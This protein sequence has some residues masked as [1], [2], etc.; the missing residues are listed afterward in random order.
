MGEI[1]KPV[2]HIGYPKTATSWLQR[3]F[4]PKVK[5][6]SII[7]KNEIFN[8][9]IDIQDYTPDVNLVRKHFNSYSGKVIISDHGF[10]GTN[11]NFGV[12]NYLTRENGIRLKN[13]FPESKIIIFIRNQPDIIASTYIQY[14]KAG[15]TYS[16]AKYLKTKRFLKLNDITFFSF[17]YFEYHRI[18]DFYI[19]LFGRQNV[20]VYIFE[21][22]VANPRNF[23]E[24]FAQ[25][26]GFVY[27]EKEIDYS[28]RNKRLRKLLIKL[29]RVR[30][31]F[32][33]KNVINK[34]YLFHIPGLLEYTRD[35]FR[36]INKFKIFGRYP[37]SKEILGNKIFQ[38]IC[39]HYK[40]SNKILY[41]KYKLT[42]IEKYGYPL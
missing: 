14:L 15:G 6:I 12:R 21:E 35:L 17:T 42:D 34:Y 28:I 41:E 10:I 25:D 30:N 2:I 9:I 20:F 29:I 39:A 13:I 36:Y 31:I 27:N 19:S 5:N 32:T 40:E 26:F 1:L 3:E 16:V 7:P 18:I 24:N 11:H 8:H 23:I 33:E 4:F 37:S 38:K 22:F